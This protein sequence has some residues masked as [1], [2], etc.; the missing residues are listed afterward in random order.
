MMTELNTDGG[1]MRKR[2]VYK[3]QSVNT[4]K[5][6]MNRIIVQKYPQLRIECLVWSG[7]A[8]VKR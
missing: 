3:W 1:T 4:A 7:K 2:N 8:D 5:Y 6:G